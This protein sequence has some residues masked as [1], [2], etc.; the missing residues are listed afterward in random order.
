MPRED[1]ARFILEATENPEKWKRK[2][3]AVA[4]K[5]GM[6]GSILNLLSMMIICQVLR[7]GDGRRHGEDEGSHGAVHEE[8]RVK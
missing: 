4:I 8:A 6:Q 1:V 7:W 5:Y 2:A 3:V